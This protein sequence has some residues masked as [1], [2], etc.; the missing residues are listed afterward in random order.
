MSEEKLCPHR[1]YHPN[2]KTQP[3]EFGPCLREKCAMWRDDDLPEHTGNGDEVIW[4]GHCGL[5]GDL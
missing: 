3:P 5:A 2:G 4:H 1:P